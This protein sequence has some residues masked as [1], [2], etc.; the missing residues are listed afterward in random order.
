MSKFTVV[1]LETWPP[2]DGGGG[3]AERG[4][5]TGPGTTCQSVTCPVVLVNH[6]AEQ[7]YATVQV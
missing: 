5:G 1:V 4:G 3:G 2:R 7:I 6:N